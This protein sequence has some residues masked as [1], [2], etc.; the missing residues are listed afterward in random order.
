MW[1][2]YINSTVGPAA[3]RVM[4]Q[5]L[6]KVP[7]DQKLFSIAV[8]ELKVTITNIEQHLRLRNFLVGH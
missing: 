4:N 3:Q 8:T 6:G 7:S 2:D 5:V 1:I